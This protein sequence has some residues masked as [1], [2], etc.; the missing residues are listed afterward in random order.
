MS[1]KSK[2]RKSEDA[3]YHPGP[4]ADREGATVYD[5]TH[6]VEQLI[7]A[8]N[9]RQDDLRDMQAEYT[10]KLAEVREDGA[11]RMRTAEAAR[12]DAI[13][14]VDVQAVAQAAQVQD[15]RAT[16]L[17]TQVAVS[18][19]TLRGQ[20]AATTEAAARALAT[21]ATAARK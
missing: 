7:D 15:T 5:P 8:G 2:R 17:A 13:R 4:P 11:E 3:G 14:A 12:I 6:N 21:R 16:A 1:K 18:A 19:E 9:R 10:E 20:V